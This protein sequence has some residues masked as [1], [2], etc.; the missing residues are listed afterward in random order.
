M[1]NEHGT[2]RNQSEA[3]TLADARAMHAA[4]QDDADVRRALGAAFLAAMQD[5]IDRVA[6]LVAGKGTLEHAKLAEGAH[7]RDVTAALVETLRDVRAMA[8]GNV[9]PVTAATLGRGVD[10]RTDEPA[11]VADA[12]HAI[13]AFLRHHPDVAR[14]IH[15]DAQHAHDLSH[16]ADAIDASHQHH[17]QL[18][19]DRKS[20]THARAVLVHS[21]RARAHL[22]RVKAG[23]LHRH[24]AAKLA[25]YESPV[26]HHR[27]AHRAPKAAPAAAT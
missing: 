23:F 1:T 9:D 6:A 8:E 4:A 2:A 7:V 10:L 27:V 14:K 24:D 5:E 3:D 12:A 25:A 17:V 21:L 16:H 22:V 15:L 13:A 20:D 19:V 11:R 26:A 18:T